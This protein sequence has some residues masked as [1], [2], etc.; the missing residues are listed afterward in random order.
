MIKILG[1]FLLLAGCIGLSLDKVK[2]EKQHIENMK[3]I[4]G[5]TGYLIGEISHTHI[6]IPDICEEYI[7]RVEGFLAEILKAISTKLKE[8]EGTS[9][10][11]VWEETVTEKC[12]QLK[13]ESKQLLLLSKCFGFCNTNMQLSVI[14]TYMQELES[15]ISQK[16]KKFQDNKRLIFYFGVMSGLF[17]SI[18]LL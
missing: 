9:F 1:S 18:M 2:E 3:A 12:R 16:E 11:V 8:D 13:E 7:F 5:F 14:E 4:R 17:L 15:L 6:P 10:D